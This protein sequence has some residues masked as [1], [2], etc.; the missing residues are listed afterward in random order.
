MGRC[1]S[2]EGGL[3][4]EMGGL[5]PEIK[6]SAQQNTPGNKSSISVA[7]DCTLGTILLLLLE[8]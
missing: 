4:P 7:E 5:Q 2:K 3:Q 6:V 1:Q 8:V